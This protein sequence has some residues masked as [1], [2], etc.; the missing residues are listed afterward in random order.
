MKKILLICILS[1]TKIIYS[2]S[3]R[4]V[5]VEEFTQASCYPC[6]LQ[7]PAFDSLMEQNTSKAVLLKYQT[8]FPGADVMNAQNPTDVATRCS[9]YLVGYVPHAF[10]DGNGSNGQPSAVTQSTINSAYAIPSPFTIQVS[11]FLNSAQDSIFIT[12][13]ATATQNINMTTARLRVA[14]IEKEIDFTNATYNPGSNGEKIFKHVMRKMYPN[15]SGTV[16]SNSWL[17]GQK[18]VIS[19]SEKIP[20]YIY[21]KSQLAVVAWIQDDQTDNVKQ[22]GYSDT[23]TTF[24][25]IAPVAEFSPDIISS[26]DG[27]IHFKDESAVFPNAWLW[28]FG[29]GKTSTLKNPTHKYTASG[30]Y[31]VKLTATNNN[32]SNSITKSSIIT[33]NLS[34]STPTGNNGTRCGPGIVNLS[35][36]A[37]NGGNLIWYDQN[38][39]QVATGNTYSP[40]INNTTNYF[41]QEFIPNSSTYVGPVD[42]AMGKGIFFPANSTAVRGLYFDVLKH[43][44]LKSVKVYANSSASRTIDLFDYKGNKINS[45]TSNIPAGMSRVNVN[46]A[47]TGGTKYF[48]RFA[49]GTAMDIYC[50]YNNTVWPYSNNII[51]ITGTDNSSTLYYYYFYDF[52]TIED[53]C[54]TIPITVIGTT[55]SVIPVISANG[56]ILT[57]NSGMSAYQ[58]YLNGT[59]IPGA[60][61]LTY[62][63]TQTG[64]YTVEITDANGCKA[65]S[66]PHIITGNDEIKFN[67]G[68]IQ[69]LPNPF[70]SKA[71]LKINVFENGETKISIHNLLGEHVKNIF[72]GELTSGENYFEIS[73]DNLTPGIYIIKLEKNNRSIYHKII[74]SK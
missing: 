72:V 65:I 59:A 39:T 52:E 3:T 54:A 45:Y 74:Y 43:C 22:A 73:N 63:A 33:I 44:T 49:N 8:S 64:S 58:W 16:I 15:A 13:Q 61:S 31:T 23:A 71:L 19:F 24:P 26:C 10:I 48:I 29:D 27:I 56:N 17:N 21:Q 55:T 53:P 2:Q 68:N 9:H 18:K 70:Y 32:G 20:A 5:L 40:N 11:H 7:N 60:T 66:N 25:S 38:G 50:N 47:L 4:L 57:A 42:S 6:A 41:V 67:I 51:K 37:N 30:T 62:T 34:N 12:V 35:A 46:F 28:D 14:L 1:V 69:L 36:S